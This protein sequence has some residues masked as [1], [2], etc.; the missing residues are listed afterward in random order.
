MLA[1]KKIY[2]NGDAYSFTC[3]FTISSLLDYLRF[4]K[5]LIVLDYNGSILQKEFWSKIIL[6]SNDKLEIL[7]IAGGG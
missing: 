1:K 3:N 5:K 6:K 4:N 2:I 7:T